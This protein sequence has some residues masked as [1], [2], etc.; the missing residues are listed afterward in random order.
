[1]VRAFEDELRRLE[2]TGQLDWQALPFDATTAGRLA[3]E[4]VY[5]EYVED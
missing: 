1:M 3:A 4:W 5:V 2:E